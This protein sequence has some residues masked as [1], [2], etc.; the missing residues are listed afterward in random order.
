MN[1]KNYRKTP[2]NSISTYLSI[3]QHTKANSAGE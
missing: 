1:N 3:T 2:L